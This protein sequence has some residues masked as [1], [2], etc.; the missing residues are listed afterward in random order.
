VRPPGKQIYLKYPADGAAILDG[1]LALERVPKLIGFG[2]HLLA[3]AILP[4]TR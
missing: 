2:P 4:A 3:I 1:A